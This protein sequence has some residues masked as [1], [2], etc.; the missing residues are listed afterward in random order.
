MIIKG[1]AVNDLEIVSREE[2]IRA[3]E[4]AHDTVWQGGKLAPTTAFDEVAKL[5]FCKLTDEKDTVREETYQFQIGTHETAKEVDA[6]PDLC[7]GVQREGAQLRPALASELF[8]SVPLHKIWYGVQ[9]GTFTQ[10]TVH[11]PS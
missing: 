6:I 7:N 8:C 5:L 10:L 1:D 2:L 3:L 9:P 4:K 11:T